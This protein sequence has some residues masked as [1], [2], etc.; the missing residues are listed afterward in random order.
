MTDNICPICY[1]NL[2]NNDYTSLSCNHTFCDDCLK[3]YIDDKIDNLE[4]VLCPIDMCERRINDYVIEILVSSYQYDKYKKNAETFG[5]DTLHSMC[6]EC[7]KIC[8]KEDNNKF[9]CDNCDCDYCYV[10]Q[11]THPWGYDDCPNQKDINDTLDEI[12][13]ALGHDDV[14]PCPICRAIIYREEGCCSMRCKYC[15]VKFCWECLRTCS[16]INRMEEHSC[17]EYNGY[18]NTE[19]DDEYVDGFDSD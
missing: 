13:S 15:K 11:E 16:T 7:K 6:P 3:K 18:R 17:E 9:Y 4:S 14:K 8:K 1:D 12:M 10:C 5:S 2:N 19:S